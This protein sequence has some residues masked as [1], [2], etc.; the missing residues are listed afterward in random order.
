MS[1][2][3]IA[4]IVATLVIGV[5]AQAYVKHQLSKHKNISS[6]LATTGAQAAQ[7]MLADHGIYDVQIHRGAPGQDFFDPRSNSITLDP[8]AYS[9]SSVTSVAVACHEVGHAIQ[10]NQEFAPL[11][12]R[13]ALVPVVNLC[14]N[15]WI[16][17]FMAGIFFQMTQM[18]TIAIVFYS[19]AVIFQIVTLPVEFD[20]SRRAMNYLHASGI[21]QGE[22]L[23]AY[24]VLQ[25]CAFTYVAAA[26]VSILNLLYILGV[27]RSE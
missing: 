18:I 16:F 22:Q 4:L 12:F 15:A 1:L 9:G 2:T 17:L 6:E 7:K 14:S 5:G 24:R 23:G 20:A 11:K 13:S 8:D 26:L 25:A 27:S 10:Y 3:Y 21:S 19:V